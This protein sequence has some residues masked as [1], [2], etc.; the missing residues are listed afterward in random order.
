MIYHFRHRQSLIIG[1]LVIMLGLAFLVW[2]IMA[3]RVIGK[4]TVKSPFLAQAVPSLKPEMMP[5][6]GI[7]GFVEPGYYSAL[8]VREYGLTERDNDRLPINAQNLRAFVE[9]HRLSILPSPFSKNGALD[10]IVAE[11]YHSLLTSTVP[12]WHSLEFP[13][14]PGAIRELSLNNS[15]ADLQRIAV[16]TSAQLTLLSSL[17]VPPELEPL[18]HYNLAIATF[19]K[20]S[21][22]QLLIADRDP[23]GAVLAA[24]N[25]DQLLKAATP[26]TQQNISLVASQLSGTGHLPLLAVASETLGY[27]SMATAALTSETRV[28]GA[29]DVASMTHDCSLCLSLDPLIHQAQR[30]L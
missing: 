26:L 1:S 27:S 30:G 15:P 29:R 21:V 23:I 18:H 12:G 6:A 13:E 14:L 25:L 5:F 16:Q 9:H 28:A 20:N 24:D 2:H 19:F 4:L 22:Q 3:D 17:V 11:Q 7:P 8:Y 10:S